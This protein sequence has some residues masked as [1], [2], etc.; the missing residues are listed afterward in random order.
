MSPEEMKEFPIPQV[1]NPWVEDDIAS[2]YKELKDGERTVLHARQLLREALTEEDVKFSIYDQAKFKLLHEL[3][4]E[5]RN[6]TVKKRTELQRQ[7]I[8]RVRLHRERL[9]WQSAV[10][11][12]Q[13][14]ESYLETLIA[15]QTSIEAR[16][17]L[18]SI[19]EKF[20]GGRYT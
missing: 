10:S 1:G 13:A 4:E 2:I 15:I 19:E 18:M 12:V 8:Y 9:A 11:D 7:A 3:F 20:S 5:E 6:E 14:L 17:K 16:A